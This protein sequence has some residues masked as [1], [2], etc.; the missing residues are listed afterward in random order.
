LHPRT[1][2]E[3]YAEHQ[4]DHLEQEDVSI[5]RRAPFSNVGLTTPERT[6]PAPTPAIALPMMNAIEFGAAAQTVEP[7]T[8]TKMEPKKVALMGTNLYSFPKSSWN[9]ALVSK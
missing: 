1:L 6:P 7:T 4:D 5:E 8:N 3:R 2:L 9:A